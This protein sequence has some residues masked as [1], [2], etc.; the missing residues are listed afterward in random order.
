L[1]Q[2]VQL[3][4]DALERYP[5]QLSGGQRQ[6][7]ALMRALLLDPDV[8]LLDEPLAAIDPMIRAELQDDLKRIF[9]ELKKTVVIVTHDLAEAAWLAQVVVLMR[10]GRVVQVGSLAEL[11]RAPAEPFVTQFVRAQRRGFEVLA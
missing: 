7:V 1:A 2:L 3:R 10:D 4:E 6:R 9:A 11:E 8:L 5:A